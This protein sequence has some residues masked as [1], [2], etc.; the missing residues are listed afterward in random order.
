MYKAVLE[1]KRA[2]QLEYDEC[3]LMILCK[4]NNHQV[5]YDECVDDRPIRRIALVCAKPEP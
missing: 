4:L 2:E 5:G 3:A 1:E